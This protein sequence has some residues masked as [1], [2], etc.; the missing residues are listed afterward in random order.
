MNPSRNQSGAL[1]LKSN[2]TDGRGGPEFNSQ[3]LIIAREARG[4]TQ[5]GLA[6]LTGA[7]QGTISK[8][9]DGLLIPSEE[10]VLKFEAALGFPRQFF[11]I[12]RRIE[13]SNVGIGLYRRRVAVPSLLLKQCEAKMNIIKLNI[14]QLL[15]AAEPVEN[16]LPCLDVEE[17]GGVKKVAKA[18]RAMF[19]LPPGPIR[20]LTEVVEAAGCIIVPFDFGTRKI[21]ACSMFVGDVP[22]IFINQ[23]LNAVRYRWTIAHELAHLV[24]HRIPSDSDEQEEQANRFASE[25]LMP[26]D[27]IRPSLLPITVDRLARQKLKWRVSMQ[28]ILYHAKNM[29]VIAERQFR[30]VCMI[31]NKLGYREIEPHDNDIPK[32]SP[33]LLRELI[34]MHLQDLSTTTHELAQELSI[35]ETDLATWFLGR[36]SLRVI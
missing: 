10:L 30:Y 21:D 7:A 20:N 19:Q 36:P 23:L 32:E 28:A 2:P 16:G 34:D 31:I 29:G 13:W 3:M 9:E 12:R 5:M 15:S 6:D 27:E 14:A 22:V 17:H 24:M 35:G 25:L 1:N 33:R 26:E 18:I 4:L 11:A 8:V